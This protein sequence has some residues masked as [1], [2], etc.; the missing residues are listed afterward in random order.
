MAQIPLYLPDAV[1]RQLAREAEARGVDVSHLLARLVQR[2]IPDGW[3]D[4]FFERARHAEEHPTGEVPPEE[5]L[6][7]DV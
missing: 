2:E 6:R 4:G 5:E 3:P 7:D 1:A